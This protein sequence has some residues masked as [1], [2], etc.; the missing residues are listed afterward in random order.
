MGLT[1]L[2]GHI[3]G[4]AHVGFV[5]TDLAKALADTQALYGVGDDAIRIVPPLLDTSALTRFGF[6]TIAA[7]IEF[8]FIEPLSD[9][10]KEQ[11]LG[12]TSGPGGIN[13]LAYWVEELDQVVSLLVEQ[14]VCPGYVTPDGPVNTGG[15]R[16][17]YLDPTTTGGVLIELIERAKT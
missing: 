17:L 7:G 3:K 8:E 6:V 15:Q 9:H 16:I 2:S 1:F 10:F 4:L 5:V 14:G 11:L 12:V 13:H